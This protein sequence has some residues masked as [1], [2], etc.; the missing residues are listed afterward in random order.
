MEWLIRCST[1]GEPLEKVSRDKCHDGTKIL[2]PV[3][4]LQI[5]D[6]Y[7]RFL[8]QKRS[9][10][11]II[12]PYKWDTA[13]GGHVAWGESFS[14]ALRRESLEEIGFFPSRACFKTRYIWESACEREFVSLY[15]AEYHEEPIQF[16][17]REIT[18]VRFWDKDEITAQQGIFTE[19]LLYELSHYFS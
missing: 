14:E 9:P 17:S 12:Q 16:D 18:E 15:T 10:V 2:H 1:E 3:V 8:L 4:H 19:N 13:V 11:K 6:R 7:G 5:I